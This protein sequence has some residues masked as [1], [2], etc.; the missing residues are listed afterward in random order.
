MDN[1]IHAVLKTIEDIATP[2]ARE[3]LKKFASNPAVRW[4]ARRN[5]GT[6]P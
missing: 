6:K 5:G 1:M 4:N 2:E 3:L